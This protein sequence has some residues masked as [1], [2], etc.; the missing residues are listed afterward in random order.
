MIQKYP[1]GKWLRC[2]GAVIEEGLVW[3]CS[4]CDRVFTYKLPHH[5]PKKSI[6]NQ[7]RES[8]SW[9]SPITTWFIG[10]Y[11]IMEYYP[12][13]TKGN[14]SLTGQPDRTKKMY[15]G[16][17][18][19]QDTSWGSDDLDAVLAHLIAYKNDGINTRADIYFIRAVKKDD[20]STR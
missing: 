10:S 19:N 12:W 9:G 17:V 6:F 2:P 15:H 13:K 11:S 20:K 1:V 18:D 3:R 7:R 4:S 5:S 8:F 16:W 14:T